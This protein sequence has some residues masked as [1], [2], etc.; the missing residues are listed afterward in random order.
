LKPAV[1][2][3]VIAFHTLRSQVAAPALR[4]LDV[5]LNGN[6]IL[7]WIPPSD[8]LGEFQSYEIW[9]ATNSA[10][11]FSSVTVVGPLTTSSFP[12]TTTAATAQTIFYYMTTRYSGGVSAGSNTLQT[13][14][15]NLFPGNVDLKLNYNHLQQPKLPSASSTFTITKEYP[16]GTVKN[17]AITTLVNYADTIDVCIA[18]INYQVLQSDASGCV[19]RSNLIVGEY[20]DTKAPDSTSVDSI[21]VLPDGRAVLAWTPPRDKDVNRYYMIEFIPPL[22]NNYIDTVPGRTSTIYTYQPTTA[23]TKPVSLFVSALDSCKDSKIGPFDQR[24][25]TMFLTCEYKRCAYQTELNWNEYQGMRNGLLEYRIY[26][27]V[28]GGPFTRVGKTKLTS[29][30]HQNVDAGSQLCYFIRA[31]NNG[32]T[33]TSSSNRSCFFASQAGV[34]SYLY[35]S[36]ASVN[37]GSVELRLLVDNLKTIESIEIQRSE[38]SLKFSQAGIIASHGGQWYDYVD[39][40]ADPSSRFYYYRALLLDSCGNSRGTSNTVKTIHLRVKND[41]TQMFVK[42]LSWNHYQ[43]FGGKVAGYYIYRLVNG[44]SPGSPLAATGPDI[45]TY[46]D[47]LE[48]EASDGALVEYAVQAIE[49]LT[50]PFGL[51]DN[52]FSNK[53]PVYIEGRLFVPNAFAPSGVN[54]IWKPVT[55]FIDPNEYRLVIYDRW[56]KELFLTSNVSEGWDGG[57]FTPGIYAYLINYKNARGEYR[58]LAGHLTLLR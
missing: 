49:G 54:R 39:Q 44:E 19:S 34:P 7:T 23:L 21:S 28:N 18:K 1:L 33:I 24:P 15:L 32:E 55:H 14:F 52:A 56:G 37:G 17:F 51:R 47:N 48:N 53:V 43:G 20:S 41:Q 50:N 31:V 8:P 22:P 3:A 2:I 5:Q 46:T 40:D 29:F 9:Y 6:V 42:H 26:Y 25:K 13:I 4:C 36:A 27:S 12:H 35:L 10:G 11:P 16:I 30:I 57:N 38:D 45:Q 58:E